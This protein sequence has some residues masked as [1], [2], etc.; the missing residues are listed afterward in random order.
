MCGECSYSRWG[1]VCRQE[2][3]TQWCVT[4]TVGHNILA[5]SGLASSTKI[6]VEKRH[7]YSGVNLQLS[8]VSLVILHVLLAGLSLE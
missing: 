4:Y 8:K 3:T 2:G 1:S 7:F 6:F 5:H